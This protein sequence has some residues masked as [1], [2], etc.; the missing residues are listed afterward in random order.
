LLKV[1]IFSSK[2]HNF[3]EYLQKDLENDEV[4]YKEFVNTFSTKVSSLS[5]A[6]RKEQKIHSTYRKKQANACWL[7][8]IK[9]LKEMINGTNVLKN[10]K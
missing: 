10:K 2:I 7:R 8:R 4:F 3:K 5:E 9:D 1:T 6:H